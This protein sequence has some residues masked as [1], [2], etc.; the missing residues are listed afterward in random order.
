LM[1]KSIHYIVI[2]RLGAIHL[3]LEE[4]IFLALTDKGSVFF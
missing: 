3:G 2:F 4:P 1:V